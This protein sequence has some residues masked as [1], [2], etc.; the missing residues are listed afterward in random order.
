MKDTFIFLFVLIADQTTK[1]IVIESMNWHA[2][3]GISF[4]LFPRFPL[5]IFFA[6]IFLML[7]FRMFF[8]I[9]FDFRWSIFMAGMIG[10]L[11]DRVRFGFVIDWISFPFPFIGKLHIN[12]ADIAL[13]IGFICLTFDESSP[14]RG[15]F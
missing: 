4:G 9:K 6:L 3:T 8:K 12:I 10:N 7:F 5:W 14:K 13:I 1:Y 2:N 15:N 11:I